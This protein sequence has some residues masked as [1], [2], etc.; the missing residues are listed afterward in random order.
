MPLS[1]VVAVYRVLRD[2]FED[3]DASSPHELV[4]SSFLRRLDEDES[5]DL[6][7]MLSTIRSNSKVNRI[8]LSISASIWLGL[9]LKK[10]EPTKDVKTRTH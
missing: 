8:M 9:G 2:S 1:I 5:V 4:S 10:G 3:V 7:D 6:Y